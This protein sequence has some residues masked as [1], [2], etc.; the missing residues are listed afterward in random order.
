[1]PSQS[2]GIVATP[3]SDTDIDPDTLGEDWREVLLERCRQLRWVLD[4]YMTEHG[5]RTLNANGRENP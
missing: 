4:G 3:M 5:I 1:M 2:R